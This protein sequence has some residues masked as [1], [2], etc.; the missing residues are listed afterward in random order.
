MYLT[1]IPFRRSLN[2]G[3]WDSHVFL[4][5][6]RFN[7]LFFCSG[8]LFLPNIIDDLFDF[9][10]ILFFYKIQLFLILLIIITDLKLLSKR[11]RPKAIQVHF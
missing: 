9:F 5:N 2:H 11:Y 7:F 4:F 10:I 1:R 3:H 8:I 6:F